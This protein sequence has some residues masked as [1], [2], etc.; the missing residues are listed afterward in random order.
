MLAR[1]EQCAFGQH[2]QSYCYSEPHLAE[3]HGAAAGHH[4]HGAVGAGR[5]AGRPELHDDLQLELSLG[6]GPKD[7]LAVG[8]DGAELQALQE[9]VHL[10]V[11][12]RD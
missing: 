2:V 11:D 4:G 8:G 10:P 1:N 5:C 7:D 9:L 12:L 6:Q 3:V